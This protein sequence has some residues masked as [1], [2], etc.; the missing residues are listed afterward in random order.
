[1][2]PVRSIPDAAF[3]ENGRDRLLD[4][5]RLVEHDVCLELRRNVAKGLNRFANSVHDR[6][7]VCIAALF[8]DGNVNR[9]LAIHADDVVLHIGAIHGVSN[10]RDENRLLTFRFQRNFVQGLRVRDL[11]IGVNVLVDRPQ[12]AGHP[13]A[14]SRLDSFVARTTS[15][16]LS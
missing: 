4:E 2:T 6:N 13:P 10:I 9:L 12:R 11:R 14:K 8:L 7:R 3:A 5:Y 16:G 1:M 15:I